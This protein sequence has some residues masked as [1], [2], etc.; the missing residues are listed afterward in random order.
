M[1]GVFF[2]KDLQNEPGSSLRPF[3]LADR[4]KETLSKFGLKVTVFD[5]KEI[6]K[7]NMGGLLSVWS[8]VMT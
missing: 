7:R 3:E 6:K 8:V 2:T 1:D 4:I 5:E